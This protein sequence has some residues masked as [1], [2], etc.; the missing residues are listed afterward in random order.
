M[1]SRE[2][3]RTR[4]EKGEG[5]TAVNHLYDVCP[6]LIS[7][8]VCM[9]EFSINEISCVTYVYICKRNSFD[10]FIIFFYPICQAKKCVLKLVY[11]STID[12]SIFALLKLFLE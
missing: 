2:W 8:S 10:V 11:G 4:Y 3:K 6:R 12:G 5:S 9:Y 7:S 1:V